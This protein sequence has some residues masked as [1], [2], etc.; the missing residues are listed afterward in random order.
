MVKKVKDINEAKYLG[1][2][3]TDDGKPQKEFNKRKADAYKT[4]KRMA[5]FWNTEIAIS[6]SN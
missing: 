6:D 1:C 4:W 5:E 2:V 3:I